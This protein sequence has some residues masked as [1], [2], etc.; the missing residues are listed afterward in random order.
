MRL[1]SSTD[2]TSWI[3]VQDW[4]GLTLLMIGNHGYTS[5]GPYTTNTYGRYFR[6]VV[7]KLIGNGGH[8]QIGEIK[9]LGYAA[10]ADSISSDAVFEATY[11]NPGLNKNL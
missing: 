6:L 8:A 7:N 1:F 10:I 9:L 2:G 3:V 11:T 4:T 5:V